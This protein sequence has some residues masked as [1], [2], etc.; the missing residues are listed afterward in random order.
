MHFKYINELKKLNLEWKKC[1][2]SEIT[3]KT[4]WKHEKNEG[5]NKFSTLIH[6]KQRMRTK[7]IMRRVHNKIIRNIWFAVVVS[8]ADCYAV[9]WL[10][11]A[12]SDQYFVILSV[13]S[14]SVPVQNELHVCVN[15][16]KKRVFYS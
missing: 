6:T 16:R 7:Q 4:E 15:K 10:N 8:I 5:K 2:E 1:V 13:H 9:G 12:H 14:C 3:T 11:D